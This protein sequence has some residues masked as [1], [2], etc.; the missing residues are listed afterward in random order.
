MPYLLKGIPLLSLLIAVMAQLSAEEPEQTPIAVIFPPN[1]LQGETNIWQLAES[2]GGQIIAAGERVGFYQEGRWEFL[3][4]PR[5]LAI[6]C[7]FVDGDT[8]WISSAN[9]IGK[10]TLPLTPHSRYT[11]LDLPFLADAGDIWYLARRGET[12]IATGQAN[13]WSIDLRTNEVKKSHLPNRSRLHLHSIDG[14]LVV[15]ASGIAPQEL[16]ADR[17]IP[18][19]NPLPNPKD[20]NWSAMTETYGVTRN[21]YLREGIGYRLLT[22][23]TTEGDYFLLTSVARWE[24]TLVV[25]TFNKGL[26]F[27]DI[28]TGNMRAVTNPL[29]LPSLG[30]T[31]A[32]A[33]KNGRLWIATTRGI[34]L[35]DRVAY[36]HIVPTKNYPLAAFRSPGLSI[37]YDD[38]ADHFPIDGPLE[39]RPRAFTTTSTSHGAAYGYWGKLRIGPKEFTMANSDVAL[40]GELPNGNFLTN[41]G[42]RAHYIDYGAGTVEP[43]KDALG[44]I[45]GLTVIANQLWVATASG[46]LYR[47]IATYPFAFTKVASLPK[48]SISTLH[49]L[50][51]TLIVASNERVT[52]GEQQT[53]VA[54]TAGLRSPRLA[55]TA[56]GTLWL[57]GEQQGQMRLGRLAES[58]GSVSWETA[59][60][61][62]LTL[63]TD[64]HHLSASDSTL[65]ITAA[66]RILELNAAELKPTYRLSAP[67]L[68]FTFNDPKTGTVATQPA[69]PPELGADTSSLAFSGTLPFDEFGERPAFERRLL[70]TETVWIT[71]K[72]GERVAYPSLSPR[73][74]VLE[75]RPTHLGH[76]GPVT[77]HTFAVLPPWYQSPF[78]FGGYLTLAAL[79]GYFGY[80]IRSA[81]ILRR[82][83]E[84]ERVVAER[85]QELAEASAA[86]SEFVASMSHE[87]R[88]PMNG[89]IGLVNILR[90]QPALP[91]QANNLRLL[92]NCAEQLRATV[93]D[94]LDFSKIE[95]RR[96]G[97][98][99]SPFDLLDTL[100]A[101]A[102]TVDPAGESIRFLEKPSVGVTLRGDAAKLRQIFANYLNNALKYGVPPGARVSTIL[103]SSDDSHLRLTLSVTSTG[104]TIEKDKLDKL[105][106]SFTRGEDAVERNIR[107]TGLG[108]AICKRYAE[109]MGG[110]VGAVSTNGETTFYLNVPFE[111]IG[112]AHVDLGAD[113]VMPPRPSLPARALAI[114][115]EDYNR[116]VLG[117]ILDKMNYT[118]DWATTGAEALQLAKENGYDI[119]LTDYRLP[120]TNGVELTKKILELCPDPK[121]AVFAVTAYS[122]RERRDECMAAGMSGF[123]SKPITLEKLRTTL[124][125]WGD[126][127][128]T[129]I[130]LEASLRPMKPTRR[131]E[132]I[133]SGWAELQ[134]IAATDP[135]LGAERAHRLNN[136]CRSLRQIDIA[137]QLE[138][139]EGA[140][141]RGEPTAE[142]V[143][144][145]DRLLRA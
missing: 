85:T 113:L 121:P 52:F 4:R 63:L 50:G 142:I 141:E 76:T 31:H 107:G 93:D 111:K 21:I 82:N 73:D 2:T 120:D 110:E 140:L 115:D 43:L 36:G 78:A 3:P 60:A 51:T 33:D 22:K 11:R 91:K 132:E 124:F 134:Q 75:V 96:V 71:T 144:A 59:E 66:D 44:E 77:T 112:P 106:E 70:P 40:V 87:I 129:K 25:S 105:F 126:R 14:R 92:Q 80:R 32:I 135:K 67:R 131:A 118:V 49:R 55:S 7:L 23:L 12:L 101:A 125:S 28:R 89:V 143:N 6:R 117:D 99:A 58:D 97:L 119:V 38:G 45:S 34:S 72:A 41:V 109:A 42:S 88:N 46:A 136:L 86:K 8:L 64:V 74:Y 84:L 30:T 37:N 100:E 123:I 65:T 47:S 127:Q 56:D 68:Q 104:P 1:Q 145:I 24:N 62:G 108:L 61:K 19:E 98:A 10:L 122:T 90:E 69:P 95:A 20:T 94:I 128:L 18:F 138:L 114:E 35:F 81:Q 15:T 103:T 9:E 139:L 16:H 13:I 116:I 130:S 57:L 29:A 39:R 48:N 133:E 79:L 137:E 26:V 27:V 102:A 54:H 53:P 83:L 5:S 17:V